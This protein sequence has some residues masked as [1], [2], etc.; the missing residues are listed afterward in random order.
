MV[1]YRRNYVKGGAYF[2]TV[3][4]DNRAK[5][6]C[7]PLARQCLRQA[8]QKC[9]Q[10]FPFKSIAWVLLEDHLHTIWTL[11]ENDNQYSMRWGF[12]KK[13][14][15]KVYL[16]GGGT[17]Q[18]LNES[19][20]SK[21]ERG[22]W[23]RKFWE[24]TLRDERDFQRHV[25]YIHYNPVKHGLVSSPKEYTYSTFH[26]FVESGMYEEDWGCKDVMDFS[27]LTTTVGE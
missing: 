4:T 3:V 19:R 21:R 2:F 23:Q 1:E 20:K 18:P 9:Q 24:H 22:I 7:S 11:P 8:V 13:E 14:F 5:I 15:T 25:D 17:E 26:Q 10:R 6:L 16:A 27:T 12:I